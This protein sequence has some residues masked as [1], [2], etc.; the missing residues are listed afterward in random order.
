MLE[1]PLLCHPRSPT[2]HVRGLTVRI[3]ELDHNQLRLQYRLEGDLSQIRIPSSEASLRTDDL[4]RHTCFEAFLMDAST[5]AYNEWNFS[6][7]SCWAHYRFDRYRDGMA[8]APVQRA[9]MLT[10][11][12]DANR[13]TLDAV[14]DLATLP[15]AW[16]L[17]LGAC[18]V[19]ESDAGELSY[20][21]L[22]HPSPVPDFHHAGGFLLSLSGGAP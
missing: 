15:L 18:A 10:V 6:P 14:V 20:W 8:D 19:I 3:T 12:R 13:M 17:R 1:A 5:P 11:A 22:A 21:A 7:S 4:W 16:P 9:P 2:A